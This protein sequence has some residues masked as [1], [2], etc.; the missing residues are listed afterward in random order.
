MELNKSETNFKIGNVS[1]E[2]DPRILAKSY[3]MY[4]IGEFNIL[5]MEPN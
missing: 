1:Q 2:E 4:N 5:Q 3:L